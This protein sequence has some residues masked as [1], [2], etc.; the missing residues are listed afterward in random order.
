MLETQILG[1]TYLSGH[2]LRDAGAAVA[3]RPATDR[4]RGG[5]RP[6]RSDRHRL[7]HRPTVVRPVR[8]DRSR[9]VDRRELAAVDHRAG[10]R[11]G[12]GPLRVAARA[13]RRGDPGAGH[14]V[15]HPQR[16]GRQ[17]RQPGHPRPL[18]RPR[19]LCA[20]PPRRLPAAR[21]AVSAV[22]GSGASAAAGA[23]AGRAHRRL[24]AGAAAGPAS[25]GHRGPGVAVHRITGAGHDHVLGRPVVYSFPGDAGRR[26]HPRGVHPPSR[27]HPADRRHP[28]RG[29]PVVGEVA[30]LL[31]AQHQQE[32]P[33]PGPAP[34]AR[35]G[36][37]VP[38]DRFLRCGGGKLHP[39]RPR[40]DRAGFRGGAS[41]PARRDPDADARL[42]A[43]RA[44]AR[45]PGLRLRHRIRRRAGLADRLPGPQPV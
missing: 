17:R 27:R 23:A 2:L 15:P 21:P 7:R 8:D 25:P 35:P 36:G 6:G 20:Q 12:R 33:D 38:A 40:P 44:V 29:G 39:A 5:P 10:Q 32:G 11:A 42:R 13:H 24:P 14:R 43:G 45:Q 9:R 22:P 30:D 34:P 41:D 28:G 4:A 37:V 26:R 18:P 3:R 31:R 16:P 19:L 1:L